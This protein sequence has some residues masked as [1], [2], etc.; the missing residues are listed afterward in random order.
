MLMAV[1]RGLI[2][3][4]PLTG[5]MVYL[6]ANLPLGPAGVGVLIPD[7]EGDLRPLRKLTET[8][9]VIA[10]F[11]IGMYLRVPL[12]D[13]LW[14]LTL[15]LVGPA[16]I[17]TIA[18]LYAGL[19]WTFAVSVVWGIVSALGIGWAFGAGVVILATRLR[20][21]YE[22]ALGLEAFFALG[23]MALSYGCAL[24]AHGYAFIAVFAAGVALRREEMKATGRQV[25]N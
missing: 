23:L 17:V 18:L 2:A 20:T 7:I 15:R 8:G 6:F 1:A 12:S 24:L 10:L 13:R 9:L 14:L 25:D 11:A 5:A 4:L 21:R 16:M 22:Q 3:R 19:S